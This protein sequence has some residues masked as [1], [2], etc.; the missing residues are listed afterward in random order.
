MLAGSDQSAQAAL[1]QAAELGP[2]E[3]RSMAN[4]VLQRI[5]EAKS[6]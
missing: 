6:Q 2:K 3:I 5:K 4:A 1:H